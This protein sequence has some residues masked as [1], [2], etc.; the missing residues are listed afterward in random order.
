MSTTFAVILKDGETRD[1]ARRVGGGV[2]GAE[3]WFTDMIAELLPDATEVYPTDNTA[4]GIHTIGDIRAHIEKQQSGMED[5]LEEAEEWINTKDIVM[6]T[7]RTAFVTLKDAWHKP[8]DYVEVTEWTNGEGWDI[9]I[10]DKKIFSIHF[11]EYEAIKSMIKHLENLN[12]CNKA[13]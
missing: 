7:R 8:H 11:T 6:S 5:V 3:M 10:S 12:E 1:I 4:Q 13:E 2:L 9:A